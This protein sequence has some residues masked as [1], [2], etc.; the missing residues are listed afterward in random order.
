MTIEEQ[1]LKVIG[2]DALL[3]GVQEMLSAGYRLVA[4]SCA[5]VEEQYEISYSFGHD[6]LFTTL[7]IVISGDQEVPSIS[8]MYWG[9]FIYE[10]E[11]HDLFGIPVKGMN[12]DFKGTLIRTA[13]QYPFRVTTFRGEG[14]CQNR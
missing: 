11:M 1:P 3:G 5:K 9:A 12:I 7:R 14:P 2:V 13:K 10:N 4:I 8:S 6:L